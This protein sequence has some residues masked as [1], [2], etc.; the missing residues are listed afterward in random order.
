MKK[1]IVGLF[2]LFSTAVFAHP[3]GGTMPARLKT[4][5]DNLGT[6]SANFTQVKILPESTK[7]FKS[8]GR[9][10]F[11]K[12]TGFTWHQIKPSETIFT[13]TLTSYCLNGESA[14]LNEL[15]YF[16]QIQ[17]M[18]DEMLNGDMSDFLFAFD[19]DYV[20][21]KNANGWHIVATPR[22]SAMT[23]FIQD[24]TI[25]GTTKDLT[26]IIITY[27]DGTILILNFTRSSKD[28]N[29]EIVC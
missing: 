16:N 22:L 1:F 2:M 10:K 5:V 18:I 3:L 8:S 15:P 28:F 7:Q 9:V 20:D 11:I 26:K 12:G 23:D 21:D 14:E 19:A 4:F 27:A 24:L 13:S 25:Y 6:V 17:S 29:Y